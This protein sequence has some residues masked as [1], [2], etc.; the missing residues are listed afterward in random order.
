MSSG[1][2]SLIRAIK[3]QIVIDEEHNPVAVL[4][5]YDDWLE[6]ELL[7]TLN[8]EEKGP[9]DLNQFAGTL[10]LTEDPLE[11]QRRSRGE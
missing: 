4:I 9:V 2:R 8:Y 11:Y 7:L 5:N 3:K 10:E 1:R 6:I